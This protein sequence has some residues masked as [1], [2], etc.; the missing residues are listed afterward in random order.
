VANKPVA[1]IVNQKHEARAARERRQNRIITIVAAIVAITV[2][3]LIIAAL[4]NEYWLKPLQAVAKVGDQKITVTQFQNRVRYSQ[5]QLLQQR[6]QYQSFKSLYATDQSTSDYFDSLIAQIENKLTNPNQLGA[7][8][9]DQLI[10]EAIVQQEAKKLGISVSDEEVETAFRE[11]F[12]YYA[13]G[14]PTPTVTWVPVATSTLSPTQEWLTR[15]TTGPTPTA[16]ATLQPTPTFTPLPPTATATPGEAPTATATVTPMPTA[17]PITLESYQQG[18]K[19]YIDSV[20]TN[21]NNSLPE[22]EIRN[23]MRSF[24]LQQKVYEAVT[25][26]LKP[27]EEQVWARHILVGSEEEAK[28]VLDRLN[29]GEDWYILAAELSLDSSNKDRGGDLSWFGRGQMD[30]AFEEAAFKLGIGEISQPVQSQFGWHIIQVLG[31]EVRPLDPYAFEQAR[32]K[33]FNT[34]L[35]QKKTEI[36]IEKYDSVWQA[37]VPTPYVPEAQ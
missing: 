13:N 34:W 18:Y 21:T 36:T 37:V 30:P 1:K 28:A 22:S 24:L 29:K 11:N 14:T 26:D 9:L 25:A 31:H 7:E 33:A 19:Q 12:G 4:V 15:P 3:G 32:Q 16:T 5:L 27:E 8:V 17:T 10:N 23:L 35:E 6:S 20:K 2:I